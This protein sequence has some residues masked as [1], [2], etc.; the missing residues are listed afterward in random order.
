M[1]KLLY[2]L[3]AIASVLL[4]CFVDKEALAQEP[5]LPVVVS[6]APQKYVVE[7]IAGNLVSVTVL[8]KPGADPHSYEPGPAQMREC[9]AAKLYF[10]I[11]VPFEE[12]WLPRI[13]VIN[14]QLRIVSTIR[15]MQRSGFS[16]SLEA[17]EDPLHDGKHGHITH[18]D[19]H[20]P[21]QQDGGI[22]ASEETHEHHDMDAHEHGH[23]HG[24][25]N[26]PGHRHNGD[27]LDAH[28]H[29][30]DGDD[31][32]V[33][34]SPLLVK[35]ML[36]V[37][38]E[39]LNEAL[40][41]HTAT[42]QANAEAFAEELQDLHEELK[43]L[44]AATPESR[45]VFLNFHPSWGYLAR[46]FGLTELSIEMEGKE[47]GPR[48]MKSII[49][50][51]REHGLNTIFVEPQFPTAAASAMAANIKAE[52]KRI[53][54]LAENLPDNLRQVARALSDSFPK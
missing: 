30:H 12:V 33:W 19:R 28:G 34:L 13:A 53:D 52:V 25:H 29:Q 48:A 45:R 2:G 44:F 47:P 23:N 49:D 38:T 7:R 50:A 24:Q 37:I 51:A 32:H 5:P 46:E 26:E 36:P 54:P 6:I 10:S 1:I 39:A 3:I 40:P 21:E 8:V 18:A 35:Q 31:P 14:K 9:A 20:T 15:G 41:G 4:F 43:S 17:E 42:F 22:P 11:G 27:V 16:G